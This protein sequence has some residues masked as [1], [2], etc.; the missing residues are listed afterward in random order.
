MT[1]RG[2]RVRA[3]VPCNVHGQLFIKAGRTFPVPKSV[4][5]FRVASGPRKRLNLREFGTTLQLQ[6]DGHVICTGPA[7][8]SFASTNAQLAIGLLR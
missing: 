4:R 7:A 6:G 1:S 2:K 8:L 3:E 5:L